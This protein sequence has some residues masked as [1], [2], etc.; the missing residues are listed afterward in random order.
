MQLIFMLPAWVALDSV[1]GEYMFA[2]QETQ[3]DLHKY[4]MENPSYEEAEKDV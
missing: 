3:R 2:I 4:I 1:C